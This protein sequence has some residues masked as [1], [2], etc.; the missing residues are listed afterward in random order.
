MKRFLLAVAV[1]GL[2]GYLAYADTGHESAARIERGSYIQSRTITLTTFTAVEF[3]PASVKRPDSLCKN[4]SSYTVFIGSATTPA[5]Y[6]VT[7]GLPVGAS[8]YFTLDGSM[9]GSIS[10]IAEDTA[11][12]VKIKCLDGLVR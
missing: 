6:L 11:S 8:E 2:F 9:T 10:A 4:Y 3:M 5:T 7:I 12:N 1:M